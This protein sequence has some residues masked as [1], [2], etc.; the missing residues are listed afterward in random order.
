MHT[1]LNDSPTSV[2]VQIEIEQVFHVL[3]HRCPS[4]VK[5]WALEVRH[6]LEELL[7]HGVLQIVDHKEQNQHLGGGGEVAFAQQRESC[8]RHLLDGVI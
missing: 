3:G 5:A 1:L 2:V 6:G 4:G 8:M 7:P